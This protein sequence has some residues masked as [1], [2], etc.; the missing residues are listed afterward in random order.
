MRLVQAAFD[1]PF[2]YFFHF[3][4]EMLFDRN[5]QEVG[6]TTNSKNSLRWINKTWNMQNGNTM[7]AGS[8]CGISQ[9]KGWMKQYSAS[10]EELKLVKCQAP[11]IKWI[12]RICAS[13]L[14]KLVHDTLF[15]A[16]PLTCPQCWHT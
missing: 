7:R 6:A 5:G 14:Y 15:S 12:K 1:Q 3:T 9:D 10:S 13:E 4:A 16:T 11:Q 8:F 2:I